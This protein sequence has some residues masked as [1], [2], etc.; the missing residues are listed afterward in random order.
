MRIGLYGS[1]EREGQAE[2]IERLGA[3]RDN[4]SERR[5]KLKRENEYRIK[6]LANAEKGSNQDKRNEWIRRSSL[7]QRR[8]EP[9]YQEHKRKVAENK[10]SEPITVSEQQT[11][12]DGFTD[13][14]LLSLAITKGEHT[15]S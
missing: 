8:Q 13:A 10:C 12:E 1:V 6:C 15:Q 11:F 9:L 3:K 7:S 14:H 4:S 5:R 2:G